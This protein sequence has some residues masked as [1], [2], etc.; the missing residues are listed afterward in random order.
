[1]SAQ[2]WKR[3]C[4]F[5]RLLD[6]HVCIWGILLHNVRKPSFFELIIYANLLTALLVFGLCY[7]IIA[8]VRHI[9]E[10]MLLR[11]QLVLRLVTTF[12]GSS[13]PVFNQATQA[14]SS[15]DRC[16]DYRGWFRPSLGKNGASKAMTLR[17]FINQFVNLKKYFACVRYLTLWLWPLPWPCLWRFGLHRAS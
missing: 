13:I 2:Y 15:V 4:D 5:G 7:H 17:R 8:K 10:V 16:D 3:Y 6:R 9:N 11:A 14:Q 12:G 1:M